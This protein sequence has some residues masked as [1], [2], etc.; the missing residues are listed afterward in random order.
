MRS[1]AE[2]GEKRRT[3]CASAGEK[4][5]ISYVGMSRT[6]SYDVFDW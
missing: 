6:P 2:R 5:A 4:Q 3:S 1:R